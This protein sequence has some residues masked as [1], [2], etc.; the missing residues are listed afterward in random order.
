MAPSSDLSAL[1]GFSALQMNTL[2]SIIA[3]A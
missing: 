3:P 2:N 1:T